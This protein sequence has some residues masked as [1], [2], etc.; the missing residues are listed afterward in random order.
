MASPYSSTCKNVYFGIKDIVRV[1]RWLLEEK[2]NNTKGNGTK[3]LSDAYNN[4][5]E[6]DS[7]VLA[8]NIQKDDIKFGQYMSI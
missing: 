8:Y 1:S 4:C 5:I 6:F 2:Y 7:I 3:L